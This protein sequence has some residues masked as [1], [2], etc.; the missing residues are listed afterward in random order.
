[1]QFLVHLVDW[2]FQTAAGRTPCASHHG[3]ETVILPEMDCDRKMVCKALF[4]GVEYP[5]HG[6][7]LHH[8]VDIITASRPGELAVRSRIDVIDRKS[9]ARGSNRLADGIAIIEVVK[10]PV[11]W[12]AD[13]D[14]AD[15][16]LPVYNVFGF[17]KILAAHTNISCPTG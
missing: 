2:L 4:H 10:R 3:I 7:R 8:V 9:V 16:V 17:S 12:L 13:A 6:F 11:F 5:G 14:R 15:G 1:M